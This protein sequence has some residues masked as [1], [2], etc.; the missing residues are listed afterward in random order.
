M[1]STPHILHVEPAPLLGSEVV[2]VVVVIV[3]V[4][5]G[6]RRRRTSHEHDADDAD[7]K[8]NIL[9]FRRNVR[10]QD[11]ANHGPARVRLIVCNPDKGERGRVI[12]FQFHTSHFII[13]MTFKTRTRRRIHS[14]PAVTVE[15]EGEATRKT[16]SR[17]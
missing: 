8:A 6:G 4:V 11:V 1:A 3:F 10:R 16:E 7:R 5:S 2:V 9:A 14:P 13:I 17:E 15:H 12:H